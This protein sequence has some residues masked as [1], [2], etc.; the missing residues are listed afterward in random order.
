MSHTAITVRE[1]LG[2]CQ[3]LASSTA[4][5][6]ENRIERPFRDGATATQHMILAET[7]LDIYGRLLLGQPAAT[8]LI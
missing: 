3:R 4:I 6:T 5:Y 1:V 7:H 2:T 8:P